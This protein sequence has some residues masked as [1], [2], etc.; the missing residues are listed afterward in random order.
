ME[1]LNDEQKENLHRL[2]REAQNKGEK[3][4]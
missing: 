3:E 2:Q 1:A 4:N